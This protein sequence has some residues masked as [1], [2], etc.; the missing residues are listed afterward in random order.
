MRGTPG[1]VHT[2]ARV[3]PGYAVQFGC[4]PRWD[5]AFSVAIVLGLGAVP[6]P[7]FGH[8][9]PTQEPNEAT[10]ERQFFRLAAKARAAAAVASVYDTPAVAGCNTNE[11]AIGLLMD[12]FRDVDVVLRRVGVWLARQNVSGEVVLWMKRRPGRIW[13]KRSED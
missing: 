8:G 12:D 4:R 7:A 6:L 5:P 11:W 13:L 2:Q 1:D 10:I 9:D 3:Y